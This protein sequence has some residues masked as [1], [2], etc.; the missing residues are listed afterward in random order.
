M[1]DGS[2]CV[3]NITTA[4]RI[5]RAALGVVVLGATAAAWVVLLGR[6]VTP[7]ALML[8]PPVAFGWLCIMQAVANT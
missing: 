7:E 4:G 8:F 6:A 1:D 5:R 3:T 2:V